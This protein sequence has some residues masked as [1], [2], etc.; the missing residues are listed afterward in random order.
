M[1]VG[2]KTVLSVVT[3]Q[4]LAEA[5]ISRAAALAEGFDAHLDVMAFGVDRTQTGYY[6]AGAN[7]MVLQETLNRATA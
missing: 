6:Y 4:D 5:T 7:A 1:T 3:D 2:Y